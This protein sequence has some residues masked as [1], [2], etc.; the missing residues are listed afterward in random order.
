[1]HNTF[2]S[3]PI[4]YIIGVERNQQLEWVIFLNKPDLIQKY[5]PPSSVTPK[6]RMKQPCAEIRSTRQPQHQ[7]TAPTALPPPATAIHPNA[8]R[9]ITNLI[10]DD[11]PLDGASNVFCY[12]G[13][14]DKPK[15]TLY[16]DATGALPTRSLDG[17]Q[18][19][20]IAYDYNTNYIFAIPMASQ[21]DEHIIAAFEQVFTQLEEQG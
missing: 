6:G 18:T 1:M 7:T 5:L 15:G 12:A 11:E 8:A 9:T 20:L 17:N 19:Y 3:A 4:Q 21:S 16:T 14:A 13:L 10:P 2:F